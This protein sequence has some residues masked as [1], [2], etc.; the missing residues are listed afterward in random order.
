MFNIFKRKPFEPLDVKSR[1]YFEKNML[2]L[3]QEFPKPEIKKRKIFI[4]SQI[5]F[6]INWSKSK[7]DAFEVLKIVSKNMDIEPNEIQ[8]L[9]FDNDPKEI[10][11]G[12]FVVFLENDKDSKEAAGMY[13][14]KN[15]KGKFEIAIDESILDNPESII[16]T[17]AHELAHVKLLGQIKMEIND[18][19]LNDLVTV[20]FGFGIFNANSA[21]T[22][23]QSS[24]S[25]GYQKIGY[26]NQNEWAYS[27]AIL[28]FLRDE[29]NPEWKN[30][31]NSTIQDYFNK[32]LKYLVENKSDIFKT[33]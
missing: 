23:H 16:S 10:N 7:D 17:L 26:L 30:Y 15:K 32:S 3:N 29:K 2:W 13:L 9:F 4:P 6:P 27:L 22:F 12:N 19:M 25:W 33:N 18:E 8:L 21:F 28:A 1:K 11:A 20:F 5:D 24:D 31:L 14:D